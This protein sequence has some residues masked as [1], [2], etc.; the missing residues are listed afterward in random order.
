MIS[1]N[2]TK[3]TPTIFPDG[4]SQVWH[5][6]ESLLESVYKDYVAS[7]LWEFE[8]EAEFLHLAQLKTLVDTYAP[9]VN[10]E[11]PYCPYARQDKRIDNESTFALTTFARLLNALSFNQVT[12]IDAHNNPR[13]NA[14]NNLVDKSPRGFIEDALKATKADLIL[15][16]DAGAVTRYASY[17]LC[18]YVY[19]EKVREQSTGRIVSIEFKGGVAG[20]R[21]LI[22]D[23]LC[24]AGG[25]F[26]MVAEHALLQGAKEVHLY[27]SHGLFTKGIQTL[28]DSGIKR[29]WTRKGEIK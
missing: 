2:G 12:V 19:A 9:V 21:L 14:I 7:I 11:M 26:K 15:F 23:D 4:T 28:R 16:P 13:A 10:L 1:L 29:I 6:P 24:D 22:C 27:I 25:T 17:D 8:S 5:L 3:I 20:K 18:D